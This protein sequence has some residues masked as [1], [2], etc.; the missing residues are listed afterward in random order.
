[1]SAPGDVNLSVEQVGFRPKQRDRRRVR[2]PFGAAAWCNG[3]VDRSSSPRTANR[4]CRPS[5][6]STESTPITPAVYASS[7][8][9]PRC[10]KLAM[11][12][13]RRLVTS[14][15]ASSSLWRLNDVTNPR[16]ATRVRR[17]AKV[18]LF[19]PRVHQQGDE[20]FSVMH[21]ATAIRENEC[22][23]SGSRLGNTNDG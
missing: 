3:I 13:N 16:I 17:L 10:G 9:T 15:R 22:L 21:P 11:A 12:C 6:P 20:K 4:R 18:R 1:M 23:D 5:V 14:V 2:L 8:N 7:E 19:F